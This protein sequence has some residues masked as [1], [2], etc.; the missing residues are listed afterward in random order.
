[1]EERFTVKSQGERVIDLRVVHPFRQ[2]LTEIQEAMT[3]PGYAPPTLS[4]VC[5]MAVEEFHKL[6][7]NPKESDN[8]A[9]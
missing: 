3:V 6:K 7:V 5:Q 2:R 9:I 8:E 4:D 1:M